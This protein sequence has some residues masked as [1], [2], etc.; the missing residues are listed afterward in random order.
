MMLWVIH[1]NRDAVGSAYA[2]Y[3][4]RNVSHHSIYT[5]KELLLLWGIQ[6][7]ESF[8]YAIYPVGMHLMRIEEPCSFGT[9]F[10]LN[11]CSVSAYRAVSGVSH[12]VVTQIIV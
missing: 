2:K 11:L 9:E 12:Y 8:I 6:S 5:L 1:H 7:Q 3:H 10:M 4:L